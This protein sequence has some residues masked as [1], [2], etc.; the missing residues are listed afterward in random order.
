MVGEARRERP[1][2]LRAWE[3]DRPRR[4]GKLAKVQLPCVGREQASWLLRK[5]ARRCTKEIYIYSSSQTN[6]GAPSFAFVLVCAIPYGHE[7]GLRPIFA[8]LRR[9][10][11]MHIKKRLARLTLQTLKEKK[12]GWPCVPRI[13]DTAVST[14]PLWEDFQFWRLCMMKLPPTR[15][16]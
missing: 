11:P 13:G 10:H 6:L 8:I 7:N 15:I 5:G 1:V 16:H 2:P 9:V 3:G 12:T 14:L 4:G